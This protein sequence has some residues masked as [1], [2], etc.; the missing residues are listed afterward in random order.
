[1]AVRRDDLEVVIEIDK[2]ASRRPIG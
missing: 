1:V 2:R